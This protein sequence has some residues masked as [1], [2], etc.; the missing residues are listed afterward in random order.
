M[1]KTYTLVKRIR[2]NSGWAWSDETGAS[3]STPSQ[4]SA[5]EAFAAQKK[6]KGCA[7]FR[8]G[9][10]THL[11]VFDLLQPS[12]AT[13]KSAYHASQGNSQP[14]IS[15]GDTPTL[16]TDEDAGDKGSD[17]GGSEEDEEEFL[18]PVSIRAISTT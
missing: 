5:W 2:E 9:G 1:K 15:A 3:I 6:N 13:G 8:N 18:L 10:W 16:P 4:I 12:H 14:P 7:K 17:R 11:H